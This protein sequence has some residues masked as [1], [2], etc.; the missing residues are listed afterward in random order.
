MDLNRQKPHTRATSPM[1]LLS[2]KSSKNPISVLYTAA[3]NDLEIDPIV[4]DNYARPTETSHWTCDVSVRF[5]RHIGES[6]LFDCYS[7]K[8]PVNLTVTG[9]G[10]SK[11][12]AKLNACTKLQQ[13]LFP[14]L[15]LDSGKFLRPCK[16]LL[17]EKLN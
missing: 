13:Y 8:L 3:Q 15:S 16:P 17:R 2:A 6:P 14:T 11:K 12:L 4:V 7:V 9:S 1:G 5:L 10:V